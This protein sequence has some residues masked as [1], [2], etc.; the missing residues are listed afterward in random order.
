M[1]AR[2]AILCAVMAD[3]TRG[4]RIVSLGS[5]PLGLLRAPRGNATDGALQA[6]V[7]STTDCGST[8]GTL[9]SLIPGAAQIGCDNGIIVI[10]RV[11]FTLDVPTSDD[12]FGVCVANG[13]ACTQPYTDRTPCLFRGFSTGVGN[14]R[15]SES[16]GGST[17][18]C[19]IVTC[20][21]I[22]SSSCTSRTSYTADF[23]GTLGRGEIAGV[24]VGVIA[25]V[26]LLCVCVCLACRR[27]RAAGD[28]AMYSAMA[29]QYYQPTAAYQGAYDQQAYSTPQIFQASYQQQ[30]DEPFKG[31]QP[32]YQDQGG[33][34]HGAPPQHSYKQSGYHPPP[35]A[36]S[37]PTWGSAPPRL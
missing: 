22:F 25:G 28:D 19:V 32:V 29:P 7:R 21:N 35:G 37:V 34:Y 13:A 3:L 15:L 10:P 11:D 5:G 2:A 33:A 12:D 27:R 8:A 18:C 36:Q 17:T 1:A 6:G 26:V 4:A 31:A 23:V 9:P 24:V 16:C 20:E 14:W 30:G